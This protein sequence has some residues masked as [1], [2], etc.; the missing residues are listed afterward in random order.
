MSQERDIFL[1]ALERSS[2]P[3]RRGFLDRACGVGTPLRKAVDTLLANH[4][5]DTFLD[6]PL[7][8]S[9]STRRERSRNPATASDVTSCWK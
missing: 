1:T 8:R 6:Q 5:E 4:R 3:E 7:N 9:P 2:G